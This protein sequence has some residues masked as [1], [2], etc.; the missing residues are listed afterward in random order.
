MTTGATS[1][2]CVGDDARSL[3]L[4]ASVLAQSDRTLATV[5]SAS[6]AAARVASGGVDLVLV[7]VRSTQG[8]GVEVCRAVK[9]ASGDDS[10]PV[11]AIIPRSDAAARVLAFGAGVDA[12][13]GR[14]L[15]QPELLAAVG[16]CLRTRSLQAAARAAQRAF[17]AARDVDAHL[18]V[19][20]FQAAQSTLVALFDRVAARHDPIACG[21][22]DVDHLELYNRELGRPFGDELLL[23]TAETARLAL[24]DTDVIARYGGDELLLG[25]PGAH[26]AGALRVSSRLH[27]NVTRRLGRLSRRAQPTVSLGVAL[28]PTPEVRSLPQLLR[29][30]EQA[31]LGAKREGG[32]RVCIFQ[33]DGLLYSQTTDDAPGSVG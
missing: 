18:P 27:E 30:A 31:L 20:T 16:A 5:T 22:L 21:V 3:E 26:F 8:S 23:A 25:L 14:P 11:I 33:Q 15:E 7:H 19:A 29:A 6:E 24:R 17:E 13:V 12:C 10:V 2:L 9:R 28:F 32:G 1:L 4:L